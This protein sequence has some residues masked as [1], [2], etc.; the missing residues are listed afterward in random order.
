MNR[1]FDESLAP[2]RLD[3]AVLRSGNWVPQADVYE[4]AESFVVQIEI[5]GVD[6]D[7]V[8]IKVDG[9]E[10]EVRGERRPDACGKPESFYRMERSHG[11]FVR[12][13]RLTQDVDPERVTA[14][15]RDGLLRLDLIKL[16]RERRV[17][18]ARQ[19]APKGGPAGDG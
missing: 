1:L 11:S 5:P 15:F 18:H 19:G 14:T 13:F 10:L 7:D 3:T 2:G 6:E 4:T 12:A 17:A 16:P 9:D 8:E